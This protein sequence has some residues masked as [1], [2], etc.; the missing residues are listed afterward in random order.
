MKRILSLFVV[1]FFV[2]GCGGGSG[3]DIRNSPDFEEIEAPTEFTP[4]DYVSEHE[5]ELLRDR[6]LIPVEI[7]E[8]FKDA[9]T[10]EVSRKKLIDKI[11]GSSLCSLDDKTDEEL[12]DEAVINF[13]SMNWKNSDA[14][15]MKQSE[16]RWLMI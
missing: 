11:R 16:I 9:L 1:L 15:W 13:H 6:Y 2:A 12:W 8:L 5:R 4:D 3:D 10:K 7:I 14:I